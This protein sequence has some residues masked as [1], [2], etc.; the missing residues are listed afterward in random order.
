MPPP[1]SFLPRP[2]AVPL[3]RCRPSLRRLIWPALP[4]VSGG[5]PVASEVQRAP[6]EAFSSLPFLCLLQVWARGLLR[7][8]SSRAQLWQRGL[9]WLSS[10]W[11]PTYSAFFSV[12]G[13]RSP[14]LQ[15][16]YA[17]DVPVP[18]SAAF[19]SPSFPSLSLFYSSSHLLHHLH[20]HPHWVLHPSCH[21]CP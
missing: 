3:P 1:S 17:I 15:Q 4:V 19:L 14:A 9:A 11:R 21:P 10:F 13:L 7:Q 18:S 8:P 20:L 16:H 12:P 5:S 2:P 6:Q